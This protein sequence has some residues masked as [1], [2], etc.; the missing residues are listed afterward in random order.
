MNEG[1]LWSAFGT[2]GME[3]LRHDL[4]RRLGEILQATPP[5]VEPLRRPIRRLWL[6]LNMAP[7]MSPGMLGA[8]QAVVLEIEAL[9]KRPMSD[10]K[11]AQS[12]I[13]NLIEAMT[14]LRPKKN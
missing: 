7:S 1:R 3:N 4:T 10:L 11:E 12:G 13:E 6:S 8:L 5:A 2:R 9:A 14:L